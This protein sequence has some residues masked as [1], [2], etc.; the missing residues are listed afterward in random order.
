M[1]TVVVLY[2]ANN[3]SFAYERRQRTSFVKGSVVEFERR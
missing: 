1:P 2:I 3:P